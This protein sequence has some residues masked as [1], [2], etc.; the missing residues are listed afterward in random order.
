M[1]RARPRHDDPAGDV[2]RWAVFSCLLVPVVLVVYGT[3]FGGAA[4]ATLGLAAVTAACRVLLR[5]S[6]KAERSAARVRTEEPFASSR[7]GRHSRGGA[8]S[9]RGRH[10]SGGV[11]PLG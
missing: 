4:V 11:S 5:H 9:H 6:E 3:S 7:R 10:G 2:V 8:G 1:R